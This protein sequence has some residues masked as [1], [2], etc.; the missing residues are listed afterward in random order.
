MCQF[1]PTDTS[2]SKK[3]KHSAHSQHS[4]PSVCKGIRIQFIQFQIVN[5]CKTANQAT[6]PSS[7]KK[8]LHCSH[9]S[10]QTARNAAC[11]LQ[12]SSS[13]WD[14]T[15]PQQKC[16]A[17]LKDLFSVF[18]H[19]CNFNSETSHFTL[20]GCPSISVPWFLKWFL[21]GTRNAT[22]IWLDAANAAIPQFESQL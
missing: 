11:T 18:V 17:S 14:Q 13:G 3:Q 6:K 19:L 10:S 12:W 2:C 8:S 15:D 9:L 4:T 5:I 7:E 20:A 21:H 1:S 16:L 22:K